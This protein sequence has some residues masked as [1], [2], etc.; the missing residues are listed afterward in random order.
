M[1][2]GVFFTGFQNLLNSEKGRLWSLRQRETKRMTILKTA[3]LQMKAI[4]MNRSE[5]KFF[6]IDIFLGKHVVCHQKIHRNFSNTE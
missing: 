6:L 5:L 3:E 1:V 4:F 2:K